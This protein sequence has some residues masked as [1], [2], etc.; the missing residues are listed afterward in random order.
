MGE[1]QV[2]HVELAR[3]IARRFNYL[4]G[5]EPGFEEKAEVAARKMGK[6]NARLYFDL[7]KRFQEKGD[8]AAL[9]T[10][11]ALLD[12]QQS[13]S[14]SDK[15]RL[16]GYLEGGGKAIFPE[17]QALLT[18]SSKMPGLDGQKMSKSYGNTIALRENP[19]SVEEKLRTMPT[20]PAR[21][22]RTDP[23]DPDKCPVWK[24]HEIYSND[25]VKEWVKKG[26]TTAGIGCLECK[27]PL[28]DAVL[29]EQAPIR[30]RAQEYLDDPETV[31]GI[32]A[33]G[34]EAARDVARE[35]L[36]DVRQAI[37]LVYR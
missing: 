19:T 23:G 10:A 30:E 13:I 1:D 20:D 18:P 3:E 8:A 6:K 36:D 12:S 35:T 33:E 31:Q 28:I 21:V 16:F 32:I 5:R 29:A 26:C 22:R 2:A 17:P 15:E 25:E 14:I 34:T 7:R 4:Y 11:H 37:G 9:D 24:F 27:Q